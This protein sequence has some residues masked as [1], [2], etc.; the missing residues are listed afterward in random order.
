M[1]PEIINRVANSSL[2]IFDLE[3]Y[4]PKNEIV[5]FDMKHWLFEEIVLKE[6]DFREKIHQ[7]NWQ[8]YQDKYV[9][10]GCSCDAIIPIWAYM[11]VSSKLTP[12]SLKIVKGSVQDLL[13]VIYQEKLSEIDYSYLVEKPVIIKGCSRKPVP[14]SAYILAINH[15]QPIARSIMYGEACSAVPIFK[16]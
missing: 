3:D 15:I 11:L 12:F 4:F 13:S 6:K 7:H 8:Q 9:A 1:Q 14:E 10:I 2:H 16:K 5:F